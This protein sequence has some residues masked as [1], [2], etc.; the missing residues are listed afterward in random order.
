MAGGCSVD[1][2]AGQIDPVTVDEPFWADGEIP[3]ITFDAEIEFLTTDESSAIADQYGDKLGAVN[4]IDVQVVALDVTD[5][6]GN[7]VPGGF[8][9]VTC[10][11]VTVDH[12]GQRV[13][14][15]NT[16]KKQVL[17]AVS[18]RT[19]LDLTMQITLG[20]PDPPP[21]TM[22]AHAVLQPIVV[23]DALHAL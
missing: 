15:P 9:T 6:K 21:D 5:D 18:K 22:W 14:L 10:E 19:W 23:V 13:R 2:G 1:V 20:W 17:D 8:F 12:V 16:L 4:A 3:P 11:G 7:P